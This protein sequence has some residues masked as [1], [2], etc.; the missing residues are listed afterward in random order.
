M[1][2]KINSSVSSL[3]SVI[4]TA[5]KQLEEI[6]E[7]RIFSEDN[8]FNFSFNVDRSIVDF[9]R[10]FVDKKRDNP[11]DYHY[12][13]TDAIREGIV[14]MK[15]KNPD[16]PQRP[17]KIGIPTRKGRVLGSTAQDFIKTEKIKTS[18]RI[19]EIEKEYIYDYIYSKTL[20]DK[21]FGKEHFLGEL[22]ENLKD[23][24]KIKS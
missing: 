22:I 20:N 4:G 23:K 10:N 3:I 13:Q 24:Y 14:L 8:L 12:N 2:K 11:D 17:A 19:N 21:T 16:I 7:K 1:A 5:T 18:F 9:I 6:G 15:L